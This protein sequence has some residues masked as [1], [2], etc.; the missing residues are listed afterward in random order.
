MIQLFADHIGKKDKGSCKGSG[1]IKSMLARTTFPGRRTNKWNGKSALEA[2]VLALSDDSRKSE[3]TGLDKGLN[4]MKS[5]VFGG[6][7][8]KSV[9]TTIEA[10]L[11]QVTQMA[12]LWSYLSQQD[13]VNIFK[14][15]SQRMRSILSDLD[16]EV[17]AST[18]QNKVC[19]FLD[20]SST[21]FTDV[22]RTQPTFKFEI[23]YD[24]W[25][26]E[27]LFDQGSAMMYKMQFII[28]KLKD[29]IKSDARLGSQSL[30]D[31]YVVQIEEQTRKGAV[32]DPTHWD[33]LEDL[34]S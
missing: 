17:A 34:L 12:M 14:A 28:K 15:T 20:G 5:V 4:G 7:Q 10:R 9:P 18:M 31:R 1:Y 13:V 25:E 21:V 11:D 33:T 23:E 8:I 24:A 26:R 22:L 3:L 32:A 19:S 27:F 6:R 2:M 29:Q 30:R 16:I